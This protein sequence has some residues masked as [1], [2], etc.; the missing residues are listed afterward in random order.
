MQPPCGQL[1]P[2]NPNLYFTLHNLYEELQS[3]IPAKDLFH[4][5]GDE[6]SCLIFIHLFEVHK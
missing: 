1:N 4:M 6:V 5:G 2:A 3:L